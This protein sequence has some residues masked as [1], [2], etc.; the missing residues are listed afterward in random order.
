MVVEVVWVDIGVVEE[1][2][3]SE[4]LVWWFLLG[5]GVQ[6]RDQLSAQFLSL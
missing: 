5:E 2:L 1:V 3:V 4:L 6:L